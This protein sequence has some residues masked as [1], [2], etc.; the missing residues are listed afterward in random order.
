M[1][2]MK[3]LLPDC[4]WPSSQNGAYV[5]HESICVLNITQE[6]AHIQLTLYFEDRAP[7]KGFYVSVEPERTRH[8][9]MDKL[10]DEDGSAVPQDTPYAALIECDVDVAVQY[11]RVDTTQPELALMT[12]MV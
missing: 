7:M 10:V 2:D 4:Y 11:T 9:R 8:I 6:T 1:F 12:T 5:S 3:K